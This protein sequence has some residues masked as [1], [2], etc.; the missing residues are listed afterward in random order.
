MKRVHVSFYEVADKFGEWFGEKPIERV[1]TIDNRVSGFSPETLR[2]CERMSRE[3]DEEQN[4]SE[5]SN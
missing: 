5:R 1:N 3:R 2:E 4:C